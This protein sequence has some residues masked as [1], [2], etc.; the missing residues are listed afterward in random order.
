MPIPMPESYAQYCKKFSSLTPMTMFNMRDI[1]IN[2]PAGRYQVG[3]TNIPGTLKGKIELLYVL[4]SYPKQHDNSKYQLFVIAKSGV[5]TEEMTHSDR[6]EPIVFRNIFLRWFKSFSPW[7]CLVINPPE[8]SRQIL[9]LSDVKY[10]EQ[11]NGKF[12]SNTY[13]Y[14]VKSKKEKITQHMLYITANELKAPMPVKYDENLYDAIKNGLSYIHLR[15][16][17]YVKW[18][19]IDP[20]LPRY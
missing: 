12:V 19:N 6:D 16:D 18:N 2:K 13:D 3:D 1:P 15:N 7:G 17:N 9:F 10:Q 8:D 14:R 20:Y 4:R 11:V 5:F